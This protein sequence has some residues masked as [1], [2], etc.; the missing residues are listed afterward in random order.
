MSSLSKSS[1]QQDIKDAYADNASYEEDG[2]VAKCKI[3]ITAC[4]MLLQ[5]P[6]MISTTTQ[7]GTE[8]M[9]FDM[10]TIEK[11]MESARV[12]LAQNETVSEAKQNVKALSFEYFR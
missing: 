7:A 3:F 5:N 10:R 6:Q 9:T 12:W 2:S 11:Q 8:Q 4:R 1:T